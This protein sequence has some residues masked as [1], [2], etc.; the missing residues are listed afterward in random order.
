MSSVSPQWLALTL[1]IPQ[2]TLN[3]SALSSPLL[4]TAAQDAPG[5]MTWTGLR[6][7]AHI[8]CRMSVNLGLFGTF[9]RLSGVL[10]WGRKTTEVKGP[11]RF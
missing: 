4:W 7:A 8:L 11:G 10:G 5:L 9:S 1:G 2:V 6:G 3:V